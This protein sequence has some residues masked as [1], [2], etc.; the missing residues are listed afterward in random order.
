[1]R[2]AIITN[3][4]AESNWTNWQRA[5][6]TNDASA[7][8]YERLTGPKGTTVILMDAPPEQCG[9]QSRFVDIAQHLRSLGLA[10]P[11]ILAWDDAL[12]IMILE[13]LGGCDVARHLKSTP[14]DERTLY[15][16]AVEVLGILQAATPPDGL[17]TMTA[18]VGADML[19]IAFDWA[20]KNASHDLRTEVKSV[21]RD[22]LAR[23]D[24]N[25]SVLS[26]RDFH[27]E[28]LIWR[29]EKTQHARIGLLDFQDAFVTHPTYDLASLLRDARRDVSPDL[30]DQL[31][32]VTAQ[33]RSEIER[34]KDAF[35][36]MAVQR[37]L[38]ILGVF[39][40]LAQQDGKTSY[41]DFLPRVRAHLRTDLAAPIWEAAAPTIHRAFP[42]IEAAT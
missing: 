33:D 3:W 1:M 36:V 2:S 11:E 40:R 35:H 16:N 20:T 19:D 38:R 7:R 27:A 8:R 15:Q 31:L 29:P 17:I 34:L 39:N 13:D 4:I 22:L 30:L 21:M 28:N 6:M 18:D 26:L 5:A 32:T 24:P 23:V 25:P 42:Q 14:Q 37:N 41:L 9:S 10:A 12:G